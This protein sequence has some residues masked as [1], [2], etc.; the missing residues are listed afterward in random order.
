[1]RADYIHVGLTYCIVK[2]TCDTPRGACET[3]AIYNEERLVTIRK[4]TLRAI[5]APGYHSA[6]LE[7]VLMFIRYLKDAKILEHWCCDEGV[8]SPASP[9]LVPTLAASRSARFAASWNPRLLLH[10]IRCRS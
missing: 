5:F 9:K 7:D 1:M 6:L 3:K 8:S 2:Q 4:S 10:N